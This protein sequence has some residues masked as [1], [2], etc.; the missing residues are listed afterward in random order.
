[1][2]RFI[3]TLW[4]MREVNMDNYG[5]KSYSWV[6]GLFFVTIIILFG[7]IIFDMYKKEDNFAVGC[8]EGG[9]I[10]IKSRDKH[11]C[12]DRGIVRGVYE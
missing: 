6:M 7:L 5:Y 9:G 11:V 3:R 10:V 4:V 8:R 2:I 1:M 12:I